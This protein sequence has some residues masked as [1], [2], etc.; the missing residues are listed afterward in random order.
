MNTANPSALDELL[1]ADDG[2]ARLNVDLDRQT[3]ADL[4][5]YAKTHK[6]TLS[7][8]VRAMI[9]LHLTPEKIQ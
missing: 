6:K 8:V 5:A 7:K 2:V 3:Y 4:K 9:K 1:S